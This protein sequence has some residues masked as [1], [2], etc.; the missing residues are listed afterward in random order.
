M[1]SFII[2]LDEVRGVSGDVERI[3]ACY[4]TWVS[5]IRV[6]L[7]EADDYV[8][9]F[10]VKVYGKTEQD[11]KGST[12]EFGSEIENIKSRVSEI[13]NRRP[14]LGFSH[15]LQNIQKLLRSKFD[16]GTPLVSCMLSYMNLPYD[17]KLSLLFC[18]AF[19]RVY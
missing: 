5:E 3:W 7:S 13:M 1:V 6:T 17:L 18:C 11:Q 15:N 10:I 9:D 16:E 14:Q 19:R 2:K 12:A 4:K 8:D